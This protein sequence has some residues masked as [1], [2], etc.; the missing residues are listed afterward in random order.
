M[1]A[2]T[3]TPTEQTIISEISLSFMFKLGQQLP[4]V[5]EMPVLIV[6]CG[7]KYR[8][9]VDEFAQAAI[10]LLRLRLATFADELTPATPTPK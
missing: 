3:I 4:E 7:E 8:H 1:D 10:E 2:R 9:V 5:A 6:L